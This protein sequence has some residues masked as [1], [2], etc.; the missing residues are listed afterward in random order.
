MLMVIKKILYFILVF[1]IGL[2][3]TSSFFVR[4]EYNFFRYGDRAV[5][6]RQNLGVFILLIVFL[7]LL[8]IVLY[9]L[10]LRLNKY[11]KKNV[12]AV[13]LFASFLIQVIIMFILPKEPIDDSRKV[14]SLAMDMLYNNDYSS[15]KVGGYLYMFP[16]NFS[17]VLYLETLLAIL[18]DTYFVLKLFNIF[19]SIITTLMIYLI[20]KEINH[21][22]KENDY[23]VLIFAAAFIP[24]LFMV[25]YIYNDIIATAFLTTAVYFITRFVNEKYIKY[26]IIAAILLSIGNY[27]RAIG[28]IFLTAAAI[29]ILLNAKQIGIKKIVIS[30]SVMGLL[31]NVPGWTENIILQANHI[32][33]ESITK[34]SAPIYMWLNMG[35][36]KERLGF[37][38]NEQS[39]RIY[40]VKGKLNKEKSKELFKKEIKNKL[41]NMSFSELIK[42][43]YKKI[44]WVWTEG[45]Y[46]IDNFGIG[47]PKIYKV[48]AKKFLV[49]M[50]YS[51]DTFATKLFQG[52]S[53]SRRGLLWIVYVISFLMYLFIFV[54]LIKEIRTRRFDEVF[55]VLIFL[56]FIAFYIL[57]EIKSRYIYPVYPLLI[58]LS[59]TGFKDS[60]AFMSKRNF[61][62]FKMLV[63]DIKNKVKGQKLSKL[64]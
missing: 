60:Y 20:Y 29:Y 42:M 12:I 19:F 3:V 36:N 2:F 10:T 41:S 25:N 7:I 40:E 22:S 6:E 44:V 8:I 38:D 11:S 35:I 28:A 43:Y 39:Y 30:F 23:G 16:F 13:T 24:S 59:Y 58:I 17:T 62:Q 46:Q 18:P 26:I 1:F 48:S 49:Q 14:L 64:K 34:N 61:L 21:K 4:A 32:V 63:Y 53:K 55:L 9:K 57:W 51:Y 52:D 15:F 37:W 27:F 33:S 45:T 47:T 56:G 54:R 5:F 31:F 50:P